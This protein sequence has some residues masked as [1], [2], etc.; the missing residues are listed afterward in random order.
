VIAID[1]A[2]S[3]GVEPP[4][5][6]AVIVTDCEV[7]LVSAGPGASIVTKVPSDEIVSA[8]SPEAGCVA[9][10]IADHGAGANRVLSFG[11]RLLR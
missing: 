6:T 10:E 8:E 4:G 1:M 9:I 3:E 5:P 2:T 7:L 11:L